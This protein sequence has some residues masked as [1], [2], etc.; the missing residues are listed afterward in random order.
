M[1]FEN[2][3][4]KKLYKEGQNQVIEFSVLDPENYFANLVYKYIVQYTINNKEEEPEIIEPVKQDIIEEPEII[5]PVKQD[6]IG[7][8]EPEIIEPV[9][10]E[11][12]EPIIESAETNNE[13]DEV[14]SAKKPETVVLKTNT[15]QSPNT[16]DY[17]IIYGIVLIIATSGLVVVVLRNKK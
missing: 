5:E 11:K 12:E 2:E 8:E 6:T 3:Q 7:E 15:L 4:I 9:K 17:I 1:F 13:K 14:R 16:G 10:I